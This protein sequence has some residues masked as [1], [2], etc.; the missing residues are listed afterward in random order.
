M[1]CPKFVDFTRECQY[2]VGVLLIDTRHFCSTCKYSTC[3]FYK[4]IYNIGYSC[5]YLKLCPAFEHFMMDD[6][7]EFVSIANKYCL[8]KENN[9]RCARFKIRNAGK[10]PPVNLLLDGSI[11]KK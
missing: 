3:P 5:K 4:A 11:F 1:H 10:K 9:A 2:E 6:F 7:D 8:S